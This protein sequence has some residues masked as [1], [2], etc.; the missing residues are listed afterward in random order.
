MKKNTNSRIPGFFILSLSL[1]LRPERFHVVLIQI[2]R[3][4]LRF[5]GV[6]YVSRLDDICRCSLFPVNVSSTFSKK[7]VKKKKP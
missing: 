1:S 6:P 2:E 3:S 4:D 5:I 7:I